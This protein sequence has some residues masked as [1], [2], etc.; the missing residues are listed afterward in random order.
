MQVSI[1][2]R[3]GET[4]MDLNQLLEVA[5]TEQARQKPLRV[6][7][8]TSTGC[9]A[10]SSLEV[11]RNLQNAVEQENLG[12]RVE[13]IGVGCMG[14]CGRGPLV[15]VEPEQTLYEEV[16]PGDAASIIEAI[17]GGTA[18]AIQGDP[19]HPFFA[20]QMKIVREYSGRIDPERI[21]EYIAIGGYQSLYKA[22]YE[23][24]PATVVEEITQSG[25][26]GRGGGGYPT[27]LKWATVAKMPGAQKYVICN[28]DE[29]D[30]G[31]FMDR[32]VLESDP[33]LVLEGMAIAGYAVGANHGFIYVR[34]EYPLAIQR[35]QKAIQQAKKYGLLGSQI[36]DSPFDFK[37]DIRIGAG[38]FVCGE[39][40]AL[41]QSIEGGRGNPQP[42]PPYPAES[43]LWECP[44]LINNV[45]S[46]AN[47]APIIK[48]GG[49]WYASLGTAKSKGTKIFALTGKICNNG[50]IEVPM[51]IT[52]REIVEEM[53]GG[54]P[55]GEVKAVQTGGPSGGCIPA[56]LLDTPVDY[57][58]LMALGSMMGSG[59]MVVMDQSTNMVEISR[60]YMEF[61][62]GESCGKC[63]PCRAGTVQLYSLLTKLIDRRATEADLD[64]LK[65]LCQM[66]KETSLC[67][68]GMSAP[69]PVLSTLRYFPEEYQALLQPVAFSQAT[70]HFTNGKVSVA[71]Q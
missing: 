13:V 30:P 20:R 66:V 8:C 62:R 25:L 10:A 33:H 50:L 23:M 56:S 55:E 63:I 47:I 71:Q 1:E 32:S 68:L 64:T 39:E 5:E 14:F 2:I 44:T 51:G 54:V 38:A 43:G 37:I 57:D 34:A 49:S 18:T 17:N 21:E 53:G 7:C 3:R 46:F 22:L 29:G 19:Q 31:A 60:F 35:L 26:R 12:D 41:I 65:S 59:G 36:F 58:S 67:G 16:T 42:R 40:T 24:T 28:G 11:M 4:D 9:R 27:G 70:E 69:N 6:H 48:R 52:L 61:C 15:Q 45:E